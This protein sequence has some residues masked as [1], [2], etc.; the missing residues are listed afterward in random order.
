MQIINMNVKL[1]LL[2]WTWW[3]VFCWRWGSCLSYVQ[4]TVAE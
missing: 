1:C 3:L 2:R 4:S